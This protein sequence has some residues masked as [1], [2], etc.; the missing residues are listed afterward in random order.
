M[1][2]R[3]EPNYK[4]FRNANI[5]KDNGII[6]NVV[7]CEVGPARG[8][9]VWLNQDFINKVTQFGQAQPEGVKS[10]FGHPNMCDDALGTYMGRFKNFTTRGTQSIADLHFDSSASKSPKG[11]LTDYVTELAKNSPDM[12]G[13]SIVFVPGEEYDE[14]DAAG[15]TR[16]F[17]TFDE[18]AEQPL[19]AVDAVDS[20]AA[21]TN[22]FHEGSQA[23]FAALG[24]TI[25]N[26]H[27]ELLQTIKADT[28]LLSNPVIGDFVHKYEKHKAM[29]EQTTQIEEPKELGE[30]KTMLQSIKDLFKSKND[31]A[32]SELKSE[33]EALKSGLS[34][35]K[36][37]IQGFNTKFDELTAK[38]EDQAGTI[39]EQAKQIE[40]LTAENAEL[41]KDVDTIG[42]TVPSVEKPKE[43]LTETNKSA[44][45]WKPYADRAQAN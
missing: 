23:R 37:E 26:K 3:T 35:I 18:T 2:L 11:N 30:V 45:F 44:P 31:E 34:E 21:T 17:A 5:D 29:S 40:T 1:Q 38:I 15:K 22:L 42:E 9:G 12:F 32:E 10:R 39:S 25:L 33:N 6:R 7:V 24:T 4:S 20:P 16:T 43:Q 41:K 28:E 27:P 14:T 8:H 36:K 13:M 19:Q